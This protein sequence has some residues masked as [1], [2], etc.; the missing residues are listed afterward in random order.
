MWKRWN[1]RDFKICEKVETD[2]ISAYFKNIE[3]DKISAYLENVVFCTSLHYFEKAATTGCFRVCI[4]RHSALI[5]SRFMY[6]YAMICILYIWKGMVQW[7][8]LNLKNELKIWFFFVNL[9]GVQKPAV[10]S[11]AA[12]MVQVESGRM[13]WLIF[14]VCCM[15]AI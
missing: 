2:K 3:T 12:V 9:A 8:D 14:I 7:A 15:A 4:K 10:R 1:Q 5:S 11:V 6:R 13:A